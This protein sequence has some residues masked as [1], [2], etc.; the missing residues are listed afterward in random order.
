[1]VSLYDH[2][3][4][5]N[6]KEKDEVVADKM[7]CGVGY[8]LQRQDLVMHIGKKYVCTFSWVLYFSTT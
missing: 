8:T 5:L 1:M 2:E 6:R 7:S 3:D 4:V